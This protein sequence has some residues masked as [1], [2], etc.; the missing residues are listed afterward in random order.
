MANNGLNEI[1]RLKLP[2][3]KSFFSELAALLKEMLFTG[4][5]AFISFLDDACSFR[6]FLVIVMITLGIWIISRSNDTATTLGVLGLLEI[7]VAYYYKQ[8][9]DSD[10]KE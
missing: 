1:K 6:N 7:I 3:R 4:M 5:E 2:L 9:N 8:R 10:K